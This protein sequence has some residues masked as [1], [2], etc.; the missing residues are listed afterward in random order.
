MG[1]LYDVITEAKEIPSQWEGFAHHFVTNTQ[2][3]HLQEQ[4]GG[5]FPLTRRLEEEYREK[6]E[7]FLYQLN[8]FRR[9][10]YAAFDSKV[11]ELQ[12]VIPLVGKETFSPQTTTYWGA[13]LTPFLV[14]GGLSAAGMSLQSIDYLGATLWSTALAYVVHVRAVWNRFTVFTRWQGD[15]LTVDAVAKC[16]EQKS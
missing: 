13:L 8:P 11:S 3:A 1:T 4:Y 15:A 2:Y 5:A 12:T 7:P 14:L 6:Y 16:I 9:W 10:Q